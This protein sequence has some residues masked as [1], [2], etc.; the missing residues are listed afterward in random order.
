MSGVKGALLIKVIWK[1]RAA[2]ARW[3]IRINLFIGQESRTFAG[4]AQSSM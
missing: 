2:N 3:E 4:F 1:Y